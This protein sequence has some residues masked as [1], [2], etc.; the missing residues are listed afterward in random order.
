MLHIFETLLRLLL[1][2]LLLVQALWVRLRAISLPEPDGPRTGR[3]GGGAVLRLLILGDS[4]AAGVGVTHQRDALSGQVVTN[5]AR[6]SPSRCIEWRLLAKTGHT[7]AD[8]LNALSELDGQKFDVCLTALGVNDVTHLLSKRRFLTQQKTLFDLLHLDHGVQYIAATGIPPMG[9]L[10][11]LPQPLRWV[12][13]R[14][15][16]RLDQALE[17]MCTDIPGVIYLK[18][19]LDDD[20]SVLASDGYHP[21][22]R[23]YAHWGSGA[24]EVIAALP[25]KHG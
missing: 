20:P 13:G 8:T 23:V 18:P 7:T 14:Q 12:L 11:L 17:Q 25:L 24:A 6:L 1:L 15:A 10:T 2:P 21:G 3:V 19:E 9:K 4:S 16:A 22:A 5:L